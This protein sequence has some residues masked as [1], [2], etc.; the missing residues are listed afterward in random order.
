MPRSFAVLVAGLILFALYADK[1]QAKGPYQVEFRENVECGKAGDEPLTLHLARPIGAPTPAPLVVFIHGGGWRMGNK[2]NHVREIKLA[3]EQGFVAASLGYRLA[4]AHK[5]PAQ[6]Q[7]CKCAVRWLRA[8]AGELGIDAERVGAVG[9]SAG[10]HLSMLLGTLDDAPMLEGE[11]GHPEQ[12]SKVQAVVS[13]FGPSDMVDEFRYSSNA[14]AL[15]SLV[16]ATGGG[17]RSL[18]VGGDTIEGGEA[19]SALEEA[20]RT[21]T[22]F[23]GGEPRELKEA[24]R[25]ASP[26]HQLDKNDAPMLIFHGTRDLLVPW[27]Q[28]VAMVEKLT[29]AGVP[30]RVEIVAGAGHG[31]DEENQTRAVQ[32][33]LEFFAEK[34]KLER[35]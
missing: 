3:A 2:S 18:K 11:G 35:D 31:F 13:F 22:D 14:R 10:G 20:G 26:I 1:A 9:G 15:A 25:L 4:P 24:Y 33:T 32:A 21:V 16:R 8:N 7:D 23:M 17:G 5:W 6:I 29:A 34:L 12:S 19:A 27:Q 28:S 30:G